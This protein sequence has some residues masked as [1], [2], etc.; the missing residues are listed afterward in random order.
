[1]T[2]NRF[3]YAPTALILA[4]AAGSGSDAGSAPWDL[5]LRG[6]LDAAALE[7]LLH[8]LAADGQD[9][10]AGGGHRLLRHGPGHHTLRCTAHGD[11]PAAAVAGR[12]ADLLTTTATVHPLTPAQRALLAPDGTRAPGY[13]CEA[14]FL[15]TVAGTDTETVRRALHT[16]VAAHPQLRH[17]LDTAAGHLTGPPGP[18]GQDLLTE[19]EFTDEP[20]HTAAVTALSRTL[21]PSAGIHLRALLA[22][23]RRTARPDRL[24]FLVHPLATDPTTRDF[25]L[26]DLTRALGPA[27]V[28]GPTPPDPLT[29]GDSAP[30]VA[31]AAG[32]SPALEPGLAA[33]LP[34]APAPAPAPA[35]GP[36][37]GLPSAPASGRTANL[38]PASAAVRARCAG[39]GLAD[40]VAGLHELARDPAEARHWSLVAERRSRSV[41]SS[42]AG[43]PR[44]GGEAST[45][46]PADTAAPTG[47]GAPTGT[48]PLPTAGTGPDVGSGTTPCIAPDST[49]VPPTPENGPDTSAYADPDADPDT[50]AGTGPD[51]DAGT[52][53][54]TDAGTGPD[55][56]AGT[57]PDTDAGT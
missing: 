18:G 33:G 43:M 55:T 16:V 21:D 13:G 14:F 36:A 15:E 20:G 51:T 26:T 5:E 28:I 29:P 39:D 45:A 32:L 24:T 56:D 1:M 6:P 27:A 54:D 35:P 53:P 11:I 22:R 42:A 52:G 4:P 38:S 23:D 49:A 3:P 41:T 40:W 7:D 17:R 12:I 8:R 10:A 34:P 57:G 46:A 19:G 31:P 47:T 2:A 48:V 50:D 9:P 37:A 25:L 30:A 44:P